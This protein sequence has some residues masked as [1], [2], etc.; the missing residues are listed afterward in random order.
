LKTK[1]NT[2]QSSSNLYIASNKPCNF[3]VNFK[4]KP[5]VKSNKKQNQ[6]KCIH[7]SRRKKFFTCDDNCLVFVWGMGVDMAA[8][9]I[10][11][12]S[13]YTRNIISCGGASNDSINSAL[14]TPIIIWARNDKKIPIKI[15]TLK[16]N[17]KKNSRTQ[18]SFTGHFSNRFFIVLHDHGL[19]WCLHSRT[20]NGQ[21]T[22]WS[23]NDIKD[24][25]VRFICNKVTTTV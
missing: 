23:E 17:P 13:A 14:Q 16:E 20:F 7:A 18:T 9:A 4:I 8:C 24:L 10:A 22:K 6:N 3:F 11:I 5:I 21:C 1:P 15:K 2:L 12:V 19:C 25:G